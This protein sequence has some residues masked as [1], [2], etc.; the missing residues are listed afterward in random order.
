MERHAGRGAGEPQLLRSR[1]GVVAYM[2]FRQGMGMTAFGIAIG[3]P[4]AL[5]LTR[6]LRHVLA[7]AQADDPA[8]IGIAV[9]LVACTAAMACWIPARRAT[10]IDPVAALRQE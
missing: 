5:A 7:G 2:T 10:R 1:H 9:G 6:V 4:A 8:L 3:L